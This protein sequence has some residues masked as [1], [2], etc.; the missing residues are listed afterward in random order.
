MT[1]IHLRVE[2]SWSREISLPAEDADD[3][4]LDPGNEILRWD[5]RRRRR[6]RSG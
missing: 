5:K 4:R 6:R 2:A 3:R 1:P